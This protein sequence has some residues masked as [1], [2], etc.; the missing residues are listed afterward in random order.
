MKKFA[1]VTLAAS[2]FALTG[3]SADSGDQSRVG[4]DDTPAEGV[5]TVQYDGKPL[6]CVTWLG[7]H[8][9]IGM[10]CDFVKYHLENPANLTSEEQAELER[11]LEK[12]EG[13]QPR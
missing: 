6:D 9:E 11:L 10:T 1:L 13:S 2:V 12:A 8:Q 7:S 3:C 4:D 5:V